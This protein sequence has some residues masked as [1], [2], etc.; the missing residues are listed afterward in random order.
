MFEK[1][2]FEELTPITA[3]VVLGL[4]LGCA[5]G[6]LAQRSALCLRRGLVG[7]WSDCL[8]ALGA[9]AMALACA[10]AGT[11]LAVATDLISFEAHRF[12][13]S[14]VP[15]A[16]AL[17]GGALF[18]AGMVLTGGCVSRLTVL[19]GTGNLRA[20]FVLLVFAVTA[21]AVMK[22]ALAPVREALG[23][24]TIHGGEATA[25]TVLPG[26][27]VWPLVLAA[28][29]ATLAF[30]SGARISHLAMA[31]RDRVA[32]TAWLDRHGVSAAGRFRPDSR[33]VDGLHGTDGRHAVLDRGGD[34]DSGRLRHRPC[35]GR[36]SRQLG[37]GSGGRRVP[38]AEPGRA[39]ADRALPCRR[40]D[41]GRGRRAGGRLHCRRRT[42]RRFDGKF[43][44]LARARRNG[45][46]GESR[47]GAPRRSVARCSRY[48]A[49]DRS[50]NL[51]PGIS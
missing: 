31:G 50:G 43:R 21:H 5:Y 8:P 45:G 19:L 42:F 18:G 33:A 39:A 17:L 6:A 47:R 28:A 10:I 48:S 13:A 26:G 37:R 51:V 35:C 22:G 38:L 4:V 23:A 40:R 41:D 20:L 1:L 29:A 46:F 44:R 32:G 24:A 36:L 12:L 34:V 30:F 15:V 9:W 25:L 14:D 16:S 11:R 3:S 2:G 27:E 49:F 7:R